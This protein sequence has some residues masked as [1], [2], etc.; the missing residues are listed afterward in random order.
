MSKRIINAVLDVQKIKTGTNEEKGT[1]LTLK[2]S[3]GGNYRAKTHREKWKFWVKT[4]HIV[5]MIEKWEKHPKI[6]LRLKGDRKLLKGH[7]EYRTETEK[8]KMGLGGGGS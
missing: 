5:T 3:E 2:T 7:A 6:D 8:R 4:N 1:W